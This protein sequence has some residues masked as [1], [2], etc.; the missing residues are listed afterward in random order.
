MRLLNR[1]PLWRLTAAVQGPLRLYRPPSLPIAPSRSL[2][3][4][5]TRSG[6]ATPAGS[7]VAARLGAA[8]FSSGSAAAVET[9]ER[10]LGGVMRRR[11]SL[12]GWLSRSRQISL[13]EVFGHCSFLLAGTAFLDPDIFN[14]RVISVAAGV[15]N[16]VFSFFHPVGH[17]LWL[18]FGWNVVFIGINGWHIYRILSERREAE[19]L[20]PQAIEL[21]R[22]VF[23]PHGMRQ[24]D[25]AKL[26]NAGTWTTLRKGAKL[27]EEGQSSN[28]LFLIVRGG[29]D[30][31]HGGRF[32]HKLHEHQFI[33]DMGLSAGICLS[34]PV[35]GIAS[36]ETNQQTTCVSWRRQQLHALLEARPELAAAV[37]AATG[38]DLV[39]KLKDPHRRADDAS[40]ASLWLARY[41]SILHGVL[42][43]GGVSEHER[44]QLRVFRDLHHIDAAQH[45]EAL[46]AH[47]WS[48]DEFERGGGA[49]NGDGDGGGGG[50]GSGGGGGGG[51]GEGG[52]AGGIEA[53]VAPP[54]RRLAEMAAAAYAAA[55]AAAAEGLGRVAERQPAVLR[56]RSADATALVLPGEPPLAQWDER[57]TR[58]VRL[59]KLLN[60]SFGTRALAEDGEYGPLTQQAV[61]L[62]QIQ[63]GLKVSGSVGQRTA[64]ALRQA[65]LHQLEEAQLLSVVR[66]FDEQTDIDTVLLQQRL[67]LVMGDDCVDAD[68]VY[69][70]R[71]RAAVDAFVVAQGLT[72]HASGGGHMSRDAAAMLHKLGNEA[73]ESKTLG[74]SG[75]LASAASAAAEGASHTTAT[76]AATDEDEVVQDTRL[77]QLM[78]NQVS[79]KQ[80]I[81]PDGIYGPR[82]QAAIEHFQQ[83]FGMAADGDVAAQLRTVHAVLLAE[84][85]RRRDVSEAGGRE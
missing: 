64:S 12:P 8:A 19:Q 69:G 2:V 35:T 63:R 78:L 40:S 37:Q 36:V 58:V 76:R 16:L 68:G 29:A 7:G 51:S 30:V 39:R 33:G 14:L 44:R 21:W 56:W 70:P 57:K 13:S 11:H 18:P 10:G 1:R 6:V 82:T 77:L 74:G 66:G 65:H 38:A 15:S 59:Q 83:T 49:A 23:A 52:V 27:Q 46:R 32:S 31:S 50:G 43:S 3:V 67:R 34:G 80:V 45:S 84:A 9:L 4:A 48:V 71:T 24:V 22:S 60:S 55:A 79:G 41:A 81:K 72:R 17:P 28:S 54:L 53:L 20:P 75:H 62:F 25:F 5:S 26:L 73:L 47:G 61:E 42:S 85:K